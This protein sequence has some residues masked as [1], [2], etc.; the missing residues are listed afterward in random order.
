MIDLT[1]MAEPNKHGVSVRVLGKAEFMNPGLSHK[2][3]IITHILN[4][5]EQ[6]GKIKPNSGNVLVAASS[7]NTGASL[8]MI[9]AMRGYETIIITNDKCSIEK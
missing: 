9:G 4:K 1:P 2:D 7:G 3:R 8:A 5:A 6:A